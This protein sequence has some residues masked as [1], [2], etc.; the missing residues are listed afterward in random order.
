M[1]EGMEEWKEEEERREEG[2]EGK[3]TME[4]SIW[5]GMQGEDKRV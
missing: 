3:V 2:Q 5:E 4:E 1:R